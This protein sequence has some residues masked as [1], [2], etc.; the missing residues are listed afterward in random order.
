MRI[1]SADKDEQSYGEFF[2]FFFS[3]FDLSGK[4]GPGS[5]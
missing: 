1:N 3:S 4:I 2:S 5:V